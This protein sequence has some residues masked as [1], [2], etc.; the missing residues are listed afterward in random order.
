MSREI[1]KLGETSERLINPP[2]VVLLKEK[3]ESPVIGLI[4]A[5][6]KKCAEALQ[7]GLTDTQIETLAEDLIDVYKYDALEDIIEAFKRGR[8]GAFG[9]TYKQLNM[10]VVRE[11]MAVILEEKAELREKAKE[12]EKKADK[13]PLPKVDYNAYIQREREKNAAPEKKELSQ[14]QYEAKKYEYFKNK[15][16]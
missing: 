11:W 2:L 16:S 8:Q 1:Q 3:G 15:T 12:R 10:I 4:I 9:A 14:M 6:I 5:S 7:I 13:E